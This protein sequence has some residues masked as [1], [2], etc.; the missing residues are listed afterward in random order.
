LTGTYND[1]LVWAYFDQKRGALERRHQHLDWKILKGRL[2]AHIRQAVEGKKEFEEAM[3][4]NMKL[5]PCSHAHK[6]AMKRRTAAAARLR[7]PA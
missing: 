7:I 4:L 1:A 3:K 6:L 5:G 2:R